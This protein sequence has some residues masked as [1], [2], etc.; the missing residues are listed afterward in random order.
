MGHA[1]IADDPCLPIRLVGVRFGVL[2]GSCLRP[3]SERFRTVRTLT[4]HKFELR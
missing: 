2:P 3:T 1:L 4:N